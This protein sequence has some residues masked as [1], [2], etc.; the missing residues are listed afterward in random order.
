MQSHLVQLFRQTLQNKSG[1]EGAL[2]ITTTSHTTV[3]HVV[4]HVR[5]QS[6]SWPFSAWAVTSARAVKPRGRQ[7]GSSKFCSRL[8]FTDQSDHAE[9]NHFNFIHD[10]SSCKQAARVLDQ[11]GDSIWKGRFE[12]NSSYLDASQDTELVLSSNWLSAGSK[13]TYNWHSRKT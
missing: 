9:T 5:M 3:F 11:P 4:L 10:S 12:L 1:K 7:R 2:N 13:V 8:N 6:S